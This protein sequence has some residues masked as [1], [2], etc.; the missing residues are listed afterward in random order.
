MRG[1]NTVR[2]NE[3]RQ[4]IV[5]FALVVLAS[6]VGN[7]AQTGLNAMLSSVCVEFGIVEGVGQWLTTSY[8]LVLG[9]VVPL[10]S[11]FMGRFRLKDLTLIAIALFAVGA[12]VS[13]IAPS[14]AVLFLS[15]LAQAVA[16]GMLLP[17][18]QTIAMTRFPDGRK[19][20]AMGISGIDRKSVV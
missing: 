1:R 18:V 15:R 4:T 14:F 12:L 9:V 16:A 13:A 20:T 17:L 6:S 5:L 10:S 8:M 19:A 11:Y 3:H 2:E 7:L